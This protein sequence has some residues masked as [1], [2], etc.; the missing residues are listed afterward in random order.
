[1]CLENFHDGCRGS[2]FLFLFFWAT[3]WHFL[4][5]SRVS[6]RFEQRFH[7]ESC[8]TRTD[9]NVDRWRRTSSSAL[10]PWHFH[11][12][13][14]TWKLHGNS[15][16]TSEP[17]FG[18]VTPTVRGRNSAASVSDE[19]DIKEENKRKM[20]HIKGWVGRQLRSENILRTLCSMHSACWPWASF[21]P[22]QA[23]QAKPI[24][25]PF[26][27]GI[28]LTFSMATLFF[29]L[30]QTRRR[31]TA[32]LRVVALVLRICSPANRLRDTPTG[33]MRVR[34]ETATAK[35]KKRERFENL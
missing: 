33:F 23:R 14:V 10:C 25:S 12:A 16:V 5:Y 20:H 1:M 9:E 7:L 30:E 26:G 32:K 27:E 29:S 24:R 3:V 19:N 8:R 4:Y 28:D 21:S 15:F 6:S 17:I 34:C 18:I 31:S 35:P 13:A 2:I 11:R 22:T